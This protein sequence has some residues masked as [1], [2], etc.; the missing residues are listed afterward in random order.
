MNLVH[1]ERIEWVGQIS[2]INQKIM[3]SLSQKR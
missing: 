2:A 1:P 3:K